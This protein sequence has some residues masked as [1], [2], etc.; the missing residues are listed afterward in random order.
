[1]PRRGRTRAR[2]RKKPRR[3]GIKCTVG[4][5]P[6]FRTRY[7]T[8]SCA[9]T[10]L[11]LGQP[12]Y[13]YENGNIYYGKR[14]GMSQS[15]TCNAGDT[16]SS[17]YGRELYC[18]QSKVLNTGRV[19]WRYNDSGALYK[20]RVSGQAQ[21]AGVDPVNVYSYGAIPDYDTN[22]ENMNISQDY[23]DY[24]NNPDRF[25]PAMFASSPPAEAA[26]Q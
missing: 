26:A 24:V 12:V 25:A 13:R 3:H 2:R 9:N 4:V 7:H 19:A 11:G 5:D 15:A 18:G 23:L 17:V 10:Q 1:M 21:A 6:P 8:I 16:G 22:L 14:G 20:G